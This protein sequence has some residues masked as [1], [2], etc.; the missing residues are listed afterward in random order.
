MRAGDRKRQKN[1]WE[2]FS[3]A[4]ENLFQLCYSKNVL[5]HSLKYNT[6]TRKEL[7]REAGLFSCVLSSVPLEQSQP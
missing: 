4:I 6:H 7:C 3:K 5:S 1:N 2:K